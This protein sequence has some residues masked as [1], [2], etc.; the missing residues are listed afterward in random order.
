MKP[1]S[2]ATVVTVA[3]W[4][5]LCVLRSPAH[6]EDD[7]SVRIGAKGKLTLSGQIA[8]DAPPSETAPWYDSSPGFG[9]GGGLYGELHVGDLLGAELDLLF[10]SN[11]VFFSSAESDVTF[12]QQASFEQFRLPL[13]VKLFLHP[14]DDFELSVG[15]GPELAVDM[16]SNAYFDLTRNDTPLSDANVEYVL[17]RLNSTD[18]ALGLSAALEIGCAFYTQHFHIPIAFR[19]AY[20]VLG[21]SAYADRVTMAGREG[22]RLDAIE[23][24]QLGLVLGFGF[25]V[26]PREPPPPEPKRR[27]PAPDDPFAPFS[28][29]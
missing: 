19:F 7:I 21:K 24:Y 26:P 15:L 3:A 8:A 4:S 25:L 11:R 20:N 27:A 28:G 9:G 12:D 14:S 6:A 13:L 23:S 10:E 22:A 1:S 16:G 18:T 17:G 29:N 2:L 5:L